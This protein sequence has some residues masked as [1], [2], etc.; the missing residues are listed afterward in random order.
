M[1]ELL[2][3][4]DMTRSTIQFESRDKN[5]LV[6]PL[7]EFMT[8]YQFFQYVFT[9]RRPR[10]SNFADVIKV[11]T[12]LI[13]KSYKNSKKLVKKNTNYRLKYN[14]YLY[15]LIQKKFINCQWKNA[16]VSRTQ[17]ESRKFLDLLWVRY[18][19]AKFYHCRI[20]LTD[21]T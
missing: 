10:V 5:S 6:T 14:L 4:G 2:N 7:A 13:K 9:F 3:F 21:F 11:A 18:N 16:D 19:C 20:C 15:F 12:I 1:L 17:G 8:S